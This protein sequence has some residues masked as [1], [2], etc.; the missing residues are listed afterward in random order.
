MAE[1][2]SRG[3]AEREL[4]ERERLERLVDTLVGFEYDAGCWLGR[5]VLERLQST[6]ASSSTRLLFQLEMVGLARV[7]ASP[8][9]SLRDNIQRYQFLRDNTITPSRFLQYE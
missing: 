1:E 8:L 4:R 3:A 2:P 9:E 5:I 6:L 7:G